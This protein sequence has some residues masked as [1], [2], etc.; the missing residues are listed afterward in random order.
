MPN[1]G[2]SFFPGQAGQGDQQQA[3]ARGPTSPTQQ[4]IRILSLRLPRVLG[5]NALAPGPLLQGPG[6]AAGAPGANLFEMGQPQ[7]LQEL[8]ARLAALLRTGGGQPQGLPGP[9]PGL[10]SPHIIP[11]TLP[12][13]QGTPAPR[14]R[15]PIPDFPT[16]PP[17]APGPMPAPR[18]RIPPPDWPTTPP[19]VPSGPIQLPGAPNRYSDWLGDERQLGRSRFGGREF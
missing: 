1:F 10:P 15:M 16:T 3:A 14:H 13:G 5:A 4:A 12:P 19:G 18:Y 9:P 17:G 8:I 11:G 7:S 2:V 6:G